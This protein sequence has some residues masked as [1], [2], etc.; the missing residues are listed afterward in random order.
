MRD[1]RGSVR[2]I[3]GTGTIPDHM[4]D[5]RHA[6]VRD[7][8]DLHAVGEP[9]LAHASVGMRLAVGE[10]ERGRCRERNEQSAKVASSL[11]GEGADYLLTRNRKIDRVTLADVK[12]VAGDVLKADR[13]LVTIVGRPEL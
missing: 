7:D 1:A 11:N 9:E 8:D 10:E 2:I 13:L 3:R 12:R 6:M 4:R 5:D